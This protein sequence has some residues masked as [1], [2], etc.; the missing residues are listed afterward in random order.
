[1]NLFMEK[2]MKSP[3]DKIYIFLDVISLI[4]SWIPKIESSYRIALL[5][6]FIILLI[7][8]YYSKYF[9]ISDKIEN[10]I[11][12]LGN[13]VNKIEDLINIQSDIKFIKDKLKIR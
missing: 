12:E 4:A 7:I 5:I 11:K 8:I 13:R 9:K 2:E 3:L 10:E 6:S 1:M